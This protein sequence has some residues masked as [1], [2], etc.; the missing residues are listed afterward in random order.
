MDG[1]DLTA[2]NY[3]VTAA[4]DISE[5][6]QDY[7]EAFQGE[8]ESDCYIEIS[9]CV[10]DKQCND[11]P[12]IETSVENNIQDLVITEVEF[13]DDCYAYNSVEKEE[14]VKDPSDERREEELSEAISPAKMD[15]GTSYEQ[16]Q[17][18]LNVSFKS[19]GTDPDHM[20]YEPNVE[21]K[22]DVIHESA[23]LT[24]TQFLLE[25][26]EC[27]LETEEDPLKQVDEDD[28][29]ADEGDDYDEPLYVPG[30]TWDT[31][32]SDKLPGEHVDVEVI[33]MQEELEVRLE[34]GTF[35]VAEEA[36]SMDWPYTVKMSPKGGSGLTLNEEE[37]KTSQAQYPEY[38]TSQGVKLELEVTLTPEAVSG[39]ESLV[40]STV[41]GGPYSSTPPTV[42]K[43]SAVAVIPPTTIVCL[44]SAVSAPSLLHRQSPPMASNVVSAAGMA[45]TAVV[46]SSSAVPYLAVNS[47]T[48]IRALPAQMP[49]S[50]AKPKSARDNPQ[51]YTT[52]GEVN[53]LN[54]NQHLHIEYG[55][56]ESS[57][58]QVSTGATN[59]NSRS[60]TSKPPPGAVNL[61]RSY[62]ICQAVIQNSPNRDQLR[63][64]LKP[65]PSL[66]TPGPSKRLEG[67]PTQYGVVTS[68]RGGSAK[69]FTPPLGGVRPGGFH[70]RQ[71]SPPVVVRHMF[72]SQQGIPVTMAVLPQ[73]PPTTEVRYLAT[74][75]PQMVD[76]PGPQMGQY[77]LVQRTGVSDQPT[78]YKGAPPR[79]SSAPPSHHQQQVAAGRGRPASVDAEHYV[80][81]CPNPG[82]QAI[83]RRDV[84]YGGVGSEA[85]A[86]SYTLVG[87]GDGQT[88]MEGGGGPPR[89]TTGAAMTQSEAS[90]CACNLNAM[91]MC[92][93]CG[94]F[95][96]DDCISPARLCYTCLIR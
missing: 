42:S 54:T 38:S 88:V 36:L 22:D 70:Q 79:A 49:K 93:K 69:P 66:L 16:E 86:Q 73:P 40:T 10:T 34:E 27:K 33:P 56:N 12:N 18:D 17:D 53:T 15:M 58:F 75:W 14:E 46:A 51:W 65:P 9:D 82:T 80:V 67:R 68:S 26:D 72:T 4:S 61:E 2:E 43:A 21:H 7:N 90:P 8:S 44:P 52:S 64:Q 84:P 95:C 76:S 29:V 39:A 32:D 5:Q 71:P 37:H 81:H 47:T 77:I 35:P 48:P 31:A 3:Y 19:E 55:Q 89:N 59:R 25:E 83:T 74:T 50:Q 96:H 13:K 92:K 1:C 20:A 28:E 11:E 85:V 24:T 62:Q 63:C 23:I 57:D 94:A 91:I 78:F 41:G 30:D 6:C 45:K 87:G 60:A